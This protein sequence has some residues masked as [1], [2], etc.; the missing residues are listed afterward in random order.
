M[1]ITYISFDPGKTTGI[2]LWNEKGATLG[3]FEY[4]IPRVEKFL[5]NEIPPTVKVLIVE[6]YRLYGSLALAQTGSKLETVQVIGMIKLAGSWLKIPV[7]EQRSDIKINTAKW[8]GIKVPK[9]HMPDWMAAFLH[10]YHYLHQ[11]GIIPPR[12]LEDE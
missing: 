1:A 4:S 12:V 8:A 11:K 10:G 7:V 5:Q 9:G 2:A 3:T 6:E